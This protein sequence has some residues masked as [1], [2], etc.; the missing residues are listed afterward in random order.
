MVTRRSDQPRLACAINA[1]VEVIGDRWSLLVLRDVVFGNRRYVRILQESSEEGIARTSSPTASGGW[2]PT[3]SSP[4]RTPAVVTAPNTAAPRPRS[5]SSRSWPHSA[6]G[7]LASWSFQQVQASLWQDRCV[8]GWMPQS[9]SGWRRCR[10]GLP[11]ASGPRPTHY[12]INRRP[13]AA[14]H[15]LHNSGTPLAIPGWQP[16]RFELLSADSVVGRQTF[17]PTDRSA[18]RHGACLWPGESLGSQG[19]HLPAVNAGVQKLRGQKMIEMK[20]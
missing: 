11:S 14:D 8:R 4:G 6:G 5:S 18:S 13:R 17:G 15:V 2:S 3:V 19:R 9:G 20:Y 7:A 10:Q 16:S 12:A 1:A